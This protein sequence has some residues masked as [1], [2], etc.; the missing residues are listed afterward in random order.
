MYRAVQY[1][2]NWLAV[3][4][5]TPRLDPFG[6][7]LHQRKRSGAEDFSVFKIIFYLSTFI[8]FVCYLHA[9]F[10]LSF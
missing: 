5:A 3:S 8:L 7:V 10:L 4:E 1:F 2:I 6:N 9:A